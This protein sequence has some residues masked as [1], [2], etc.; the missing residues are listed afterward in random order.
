VTKDLDIGTMSKSD[1]EERRVEEDEP[2]L[3][4]YERYVEY[5]S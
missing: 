4:G 3:E 5:F 1:S 2:V